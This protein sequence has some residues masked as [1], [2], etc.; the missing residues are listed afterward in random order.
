MRLTWATTLVTLL[1]TSAPFIVADDVH[2]DKSTPCEV[3][4]CGTNNVCGTGPDYCSKAKCINNCNYKA[5]C[6]P[7]NWP[8]QYFNATKCP[9][10]CAAASMASAV[11]LRSSVSVKRVIGYYGSGGAS[12]RC[13]AMIPQTFPQG[14]YTHIYFAFGSIDPK[15]FQVIPANTEDEKLY[16]QLAALK[17]RD[18]GQELW[19]SIG[20]W[21][22]SDNGSPTATTFSDLVNADTT[23]QRAFFASLTLF[24]QTWG[25][26]GVDIDWEYPVDHD[27]NGRESDFKAYP[28]FLKRLKAALRDYK[29][30]LSVTLPTSYWYLQHFD[31]ENIEPSV[32]WFNV[33]SYDLHGAWDIGNKWTG[34][35]VGAHTNLT[36]IKSSLDL[37]WRNKVSP[38]KVVLGL[39]FYGRAVTLANPSCS[40]PGCTYLSAADAGKC[41]GEPGILFNSEITDLIREKKL[42]PKLYKDAAVKT[43]QWN[44]DQW[45]SYDDRDTWKLKAN[46][47]KSQC[48]SGVL[49]WA[50]DYD[51]SKHSY[52]KGLAAALGI[53]I[54]DSPGSGLDIELPDKKEEP[55]DFC[56]FTNCGQTCPNGY[57][58]IPWDGKDSQVM[59]DDT[60]CGG[61]EVQTLCC[62]KSSKVPTCR[63]R[64]FD[65]SGRCTVGCNTGEVEV[66]THSRG[67]T[68]SGWQTACC[69]ATDST[70][71]W[72][73][74][75]WTVDCYDDDT[76]PNGY[77]TFVVGS[78]DGWGG[79]PS[80]KPGKKYNY[81]CT[82]TPKAFKNCEWVGNED[83]AAKTLG[84]TDKCP[85][86]ST[87][88]A[89]QEINRLY[90]S[91]KSANSGQCL[92]GHEAYCCSGDKE[93]D[94]DERPK[95]HYRDDT[96]Q[97]FDRLLQKF[98]KDPV[99]PPGFETQYTMRTGIY[100]RDL[101]QRGKTDQGAVLA[102]LVPLMAMWYTSQYPRKDISDIYQMRIKEYGYAETAANASTYHDV[103][104]PGSSSS[105]GLPSYD[106]EA[107]AASS[108]CN[109]RHSRDALD[110][111]SVASQAL[112]EIPG[113]SVS[114][115]S[116]RDLL[117]PRI[118][119][120][121]T[122]SDRS[123]DD[124]LPSVAVALQGILDRELTLHYLRWLRD[125]DE[126]EVILEIAFWIGNRVGVT[127]S[128]EI[129]NRYSDRG[130]RLYRDRWVIFHFH[131]PIDRQTFLGEQ[132]E[133]PVGVSSFNM[134]HSQTVTVPWRVDRGSHQDYRAE[135]RF[136][137]SVGA[138]RG[139]TPPNSQGRNG[140]WGMRGYNERVQ[141]LNCRHILAARWYPGFNY[142]AAGTIARITQ[143]N[144]PDQ[145]SIL[146]DEFGRFL[147]REGVFRRRNLGYIWPAVNDR[148]ADLDPM[149]A[150][151]DGRRLYNPQQGAFDYNFSGDS[152]SVGDLSQFAPDPSQNP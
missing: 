114:A 27:R 24:M 151:N 87:R 89:E 1:L 2:C 22:F 58:E 14:I 79:R 66:G 145:Y 13:N 105:D 70:E 133:F 59:L 81:C 120:A 56:Y 109:L 83:V 84:C 118:F 76:C 5:E 113:S 15:S 121:S 69:D 62:P 98:L 30:G 17:S 140:L 16:P 143:G 50:V 124:Q 111:L 6:N 39:A 106:A 141:P 72:S 45:V 26:S 74:C 42:R 55:T 108:L 82:E 112:C 103:M 77:S 135:F 149:A 116:K 97:Q 52:S 61:K 132:E 19:L 92:V 4:C 85:H 28:V 107:M 134:Y 126:D 128:Q 101:L 100:S 41:S 99:C 144:R 90:G 63:W 10:M 43:I 102:A 152:D 130:H 71:P 33:M 67:C 115:S 32:D 9:S 23:R 88:I 51:D 53:K 49:V 148:Q 21:T 7:G 35:F 146:V 34:A 123:D 142:Q 47:L 18:A 129:Q 36:E 122:M 20:G 78:R 96:A 150:V 65:N 147:L 25:F 91:K 136:A 11:P 94:E 68:K 54:N 138:R 3:G 127:P 119:D 8:S 117:K 137:A 75:G 93:S 46:F 86:G 64:G 38:S 73:K 95:I 40:E 29:Y 104:F 125:S 131:I 31:L 57:T 48:L 12:R 37:L 110:N 60:E 80:C 139:E 44:N